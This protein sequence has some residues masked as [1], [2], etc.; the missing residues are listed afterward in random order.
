M[1]RR[2]GPGLTR[3]QVV[4]AAIAVVEA[5]GAD[6]LGVSRVARALGIKPP[7]LY[8]HVGKGDALAQAVVIEGNRRLLVHLEDAVR[9]VV[10]ARDQLRALG[11]AVR[12]FAR[13]HAGLYGVMSRVPPPNDDPAFR[14]VLRRTLDLFGRPLARLGLAEAEHIHA[15]RAMRAS[16]RGFLV[17]E[18]QGQFALDVDSEASFRWMLEALVDGVERGGGRPGR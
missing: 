16:L 10:D 13:D 6:A 1:G 2:P 11:L 8:N 5:E 3:Q 15:I 18:E 12:D 4:E 7:S 14:P 9:G 17:L